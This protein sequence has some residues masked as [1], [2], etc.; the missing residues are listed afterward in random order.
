MLEMAVFSLLWLGLFSFA[1]VFRRN[2]LIGN[3]FIIT[4][5]I[6]VGMGVL[7]WPVIR[8]VAI[9][10][11]STYNLNLISS[12]DF[13]KTNGI[14]ILG[15]ML[16]Y[17]LYQLFVSVLKP[18][19]SINHLQRS[20]PLEH[21]FPLYKI[22]ILGLVFVSLGC[23]FIYQNFSLLMIA[24]SLTGSEALQSLAKAREES[25]SSYF[26]IMTV[27][28][29][30]PATSFAFLLI[31]LKKK[32][33]RWWGAFFITFV[34]AVLCLLLTFQKRPLL[35]YL[36]GVIFILFIDRMIRSRGEKNINIFSIIMSLKWYILAFFTLLTVFYYYYTDYRFNHD[37]IEA[38]LINSKISIS[39]VIGRL[40]IPALMYSNYFPMQEGF[41]GFSNVGLISKFFG[42]PLYVDAKNVAD[43]FSLIGEQGTVAT[44]SFIDFYGGFGFYGVVIG[45]FFIAFILAII[46]CIRLNIR[47]QASYIYYSSVALIIVYYF[48]Q[49][50]MFRVLLGYGGVFYLLTWFFLFHRFK[51]YEN[52]NI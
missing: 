36:M 13:L 9:D 7:I 43:Y 39:R 32:E 31:S 23:L 19:Q 1:Y 14:M 35:V 49:A 5:F 11:A 6:F 42:T 44:S 27:Y 29:L 24:S 18:S 51:L 10:S 3:F 30:L 8:D 40:S 12:T 48:S 22:P 28:N 17:V 45:S 41:Y 34:V 2:D 37:F 15:V 38:F 47:S 4:Q 52:R 25:T 46:E 20:I 21:Y 16:S 50:S 33:K 26:L